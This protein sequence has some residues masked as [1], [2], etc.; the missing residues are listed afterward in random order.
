MTVTAIY[1]QPELVQAITSCDGTLDPCF[2][3]LKADFLVDPELLSSIN[4]KAIASLIK[5]KSTFSD[6]LNDNLSLSANNGTVK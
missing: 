6:I 5:P 2:N 1:H 4:D 3:Y